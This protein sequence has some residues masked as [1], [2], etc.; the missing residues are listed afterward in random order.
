MTL[1]S[2]AYQ[3]KL[4]LLLQHH[5]HDA[6]SLKP[7]CS[8]NNNN[9]NVPVA[10]ESAGTWNHQAVEL[11]QKLGRRMTAVTEDP[12]KQLTRSRGRQWLSNGVMRSPSTALSPPSKRRCG[13]I[14]LSSIFYPQELSTEGLNNNNNGFIRTA[15]R[16]LD[17]T[18]SA[19]Q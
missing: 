13:L 12:G 10:I 2:H 4:K 18:I 14:C 11:V 17:Y 19:T 3:T 6:R 7:S 1:S 15:A 16:L 9:N 8:N 5:V